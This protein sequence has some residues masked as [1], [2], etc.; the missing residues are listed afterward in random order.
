MSKLVLQMQ[1]SADGFVGGEG[2]AAWQLWD[3]VGEC[4][5]DAALKRDFNLFFQGVGTILL[6]RKMAEE[7]YIDHWAKAAGR[8]PQDRFY[9]F[10]R[11][12]TEIPKVVLSRELKD[13]RWARTR[14]VGGDLAREVGALKQGGA[15]DIAVFGGTGFASALVA[16]D[17]VDEYQFFINPVAL[18]SGQ[19]LFAQSGFRR[20][21]LL[22]SVAYGCGIVVNRYGRASR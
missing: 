12:I 3:W 16:A 11:R 1:M 5:W 21:R 10:A 6:S 13:C 15:G 19:R 8:F 2:Q 22:G 4:P 20:L 14:V 17:L 9:A 18:S 7:G